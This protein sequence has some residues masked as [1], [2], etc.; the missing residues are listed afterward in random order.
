MTIHDYLDYDLIWLWFVP[1]FNDLILIRAPKSNQIKSFD[2][3][4]RVKP[5]STSGVSGS[6]YSGHYWKYN[7]NRCGQSSNGKSSEFFFTWITLIFIFVVHCCKIYHGFRYGTNLR[8]DAYILFR[9]RTSSFAR[10]Y[11]WSSRVFI[12]V[13][14]ASAGWIGYACYTDRTSSF[15]WRLPQTVFGLV[16]L[17]LLAGTLFGKAFLKTDQVLS[18]SELTFL[19]PWKSQVVSHKKPRWRSPQDPVSPSSWPKRPPR[20]LR[21]PGTLSHPPTNCGR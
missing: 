5:W 12:N 1:I 2:T 18:P 17:C 16:A 11:G 13:G 8:F 9:S 15:A 20:Y 4:S 3:L 14:Y 10:T 7:S 6:C 19:S 21:S